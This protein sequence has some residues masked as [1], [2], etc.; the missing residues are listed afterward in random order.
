MQGWAR[1]HTLATFRV[2]HESVAESEISEHCSSVLAGKCPVL[3]ACARDVL[4]AHRDVLAEGAEHYASVER[5]RTDDDINAFGGRTLVER[6]YKLGKALTRTITL[7]V[8]TYEDIAHDKE[9]RVWGAGGF[10]Q[11][12]KVLSDVVR[13]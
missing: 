10:K 1:R 6:L 7:P 12:N 9:G 13:R 5:W 3:F 11:C 4:R 2:P 8:P